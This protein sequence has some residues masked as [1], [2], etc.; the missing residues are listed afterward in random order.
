MVDEA[1]KIRKQIVVMRGVED[2]GSVKF[3]EVLRLL[4]YDYKSTN[5]KKRKDCGLKL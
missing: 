3:L 1:L 4:V 2:R 5:L